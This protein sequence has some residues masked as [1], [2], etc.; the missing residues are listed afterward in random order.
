MGRMD[1]ARAVTSATTGKVIARK[2]VI[3]IELTAAQKTAVVNFVQATGA[4]PGAA[5]DIWS[6]TLSRIPSAPNTVVMSLSGFVVQPDAATAIAQQT[7]EQTSEII[8]IVP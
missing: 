2:D 3:G 4:W 5:K 7:S 8:G 6:V 1:D